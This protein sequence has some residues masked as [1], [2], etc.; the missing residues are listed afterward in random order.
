M[1][2]SV[3][4]EFVEKIFNGSKT[5]ELRKSAPNI[6]KD[7][8]IIIYSTSPVMAVIGTCRVKEIISLKPTNLWNVYSHKF[9]I[10]RKRYFEYYEGKEIAIG[11]VLKD[12]KKINTQIP[13]SKL[14]AKFKNFHPPQTFR[15]FDKKQFNL[16]MQ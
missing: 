7:D 8:V 12:V 14:R 2:I 3:K 9:G 1:F 15:Y 5:I 6:K 10:E 4:P 13:L 16:L 11:I